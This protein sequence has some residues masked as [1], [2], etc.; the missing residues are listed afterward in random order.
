MSASW[1]DRHILHTRS[2]PGRR[3]MTSHC[4]GVAHAMP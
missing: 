3:P 1:Y 4:W 2:R